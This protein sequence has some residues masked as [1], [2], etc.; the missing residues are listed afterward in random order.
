MSVSCTC[1]ACG[2]KHG[3]VGG[4][5]WDSWAIAL[6]VFAISLTV[7][8]DCLGLGSGSLSKKSSLG[9]PGPE[10]EL[11]TAANLCQRGMRK[12]R[13][14]SGRALLSIKLS[15]H[16]THQL[17]SYQAGSSRQ[18]CTLQLNSEILIRTH[19]PVPSPHKGHGLLCSHSFPSFPW[20]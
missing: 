12:R 20:R 15:A 8:Q 5:K 18:P 9:C 19:S 11:R 14:R 2:K 10:E 7:A 16:S 3:W 17:S 4:L 1:S 13:K 6:D